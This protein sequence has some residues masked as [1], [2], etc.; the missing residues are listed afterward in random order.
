MKRRR[1][2][3][4]HTHFQLLPTSSTAENITAGY[5]TPESVVDAW[6]NSTG[7]KTNILY[8]AYQGIGIGHYYHAASTWKNY[9][10]Q[11][12]GSLSVIAV[13]EPESYAM[14]PASASWAYLPGGA[15]GKADLR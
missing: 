7:H 6:M 5:S 9:W 15:N 12:F 4:L 1:H 10:T 8:P 13:P 2:A 11:D 3:D 14:L